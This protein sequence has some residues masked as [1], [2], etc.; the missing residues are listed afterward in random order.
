[1]TVTSAAVA[2]TKFL[3]GTDESTL[4]LGILQVCGYVYVPSYVSRGIDYI[5]CVEAASMLAPTNFI[6][7]G[8]NLD[9]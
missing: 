1:M 5:R 3:F 6:T 8:A 2:R 7:F 4:V 9:D